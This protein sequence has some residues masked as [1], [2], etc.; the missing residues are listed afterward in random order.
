MQLAEIH[1]RCTASDLDQLSGKA[2]LLVDPDGSLVEHRRQLLSDFCRSVRA[3]SNSFDVFELRRE[4]EPQ[5]AILSDA[6]GCT[7]LP[8]LAEYVRHRWPSARILV[9]GQAV[10][11]LEDQLYD[12]TVAAGFSP[13]EFVAAVA[14]YCHTSH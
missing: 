3:A 2:I 4:D 10:P 9:I 11:F 7:Q 6:L 8:E 5:I 12:E 14:R 13:P 1:P